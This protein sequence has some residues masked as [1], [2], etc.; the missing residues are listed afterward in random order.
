[1]PK[2][3]EFMA[4]A[5]RS[6][7]DYRIYHRLYSDAVAEALSLAKRK[8]YEVDENDI[9]T[10]VTTGPRKPSEGR[11][12][13]FKFDLTKGGKPVKHMLVF[14]IYGMKNQYELTAYIS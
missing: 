5:R 1:M 2:L 9:F 8:G 4:E 6:K 14:Q 12:N 7:S 11:T 3:A 13:S 10:K